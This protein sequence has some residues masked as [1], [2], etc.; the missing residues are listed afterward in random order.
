MILTVCILFFSYNASVFCR[1]FVCSVILGKDF[2]PRLGLVSMED[3]KAKTLQCIANSKTPK[4]GKFIYKCY[5]LTVFTPND[6][7]MSGS[8]L[9][10]RIETDLHMTWMLEYI[11]MIAGL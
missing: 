5:I 4:V 3:L 10:E 8:L 9:H 11:S 6:G 2:I 1:D 7:N